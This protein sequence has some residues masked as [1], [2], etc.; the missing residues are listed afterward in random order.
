MMH[1]LVLSIAICAGAAG[2]EGILAGRGV[3]QRFVQL[4]MPH[5]SPPLTIWILIGAVFY[6]ICFVVLYRLLV[7]PPTG[8]RTAA[9]S[10]TLI[11][12]LANAFWNY[13]F[14][15]LHSLRLS[16][17]ASLLYSVIALGLLTL[18][19]KLDRVAAWC[20]LPYA[21]YLS[22]ANWWGYA[23]WRANPIGVRKAN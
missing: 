20:L 8:L 14:F 9:L 12:L 16:F 17:I 22:Y 7:L 10:L 23:L 1:R 19:Y 21:L 6:A 13:L 18:L 11:V 4:R 5:L 15:R 3:K 2:L